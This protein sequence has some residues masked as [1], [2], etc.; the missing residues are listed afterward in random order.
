MKENGS[1]F[2]SAESLIVNSGNKWDVERGYV[3]GACDDGFDYA[4][5]DGPIIST[6]TK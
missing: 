6:A 4:A 2:F 1:N 5:E 3:K